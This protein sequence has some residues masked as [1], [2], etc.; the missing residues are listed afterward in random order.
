MRINKVY[1][2]GAGPSSSLITARGLL[3]LR[4]ADVV[5]YDY[6]VDYALLNEAKDGAQLISCNSLGKKCHLDGF[7]HSQDKINALMVKKAK[8]GKRVIRL[9][10]GDPS[11]FSRISQELAALAENK[12]GFEVVPGVTSA[13]SAACFLGIPLTD[14]RF[15]SSVVFVTGHEDPDKDKSSIDWKSIA[16]CGTIVLYMAV[17]NISKISCELIKCGR[18]KDTPVMAISYAGCLNQKTIKAKLNDISLAVRKERIQP[19]AIFI[20][21]K[22]VDFEK[23]FNWLKKGQRILFTGLS[24]E[25][26]FTKEAYF[27]LPLI[28]IIPISD[29]TEF[30]NYLK[31]IAGYDWLIFTSRYGA[32]YFF[33]RLN[34]VGLDSRELKNINIAAIGNSTKK[35]LQ[36]FGII[37]DLVPENESSQ[38]ILEEFAKI[39]IRDRKIFLPR[40]NLSD[41]GLT[42]KLKSFGAK[43]TAG[44]CYKNVMPR[45]LPDL[46]LNTFSE[47]MFTSPSGVRNFVQRYGGKIPKKTKVSCIGGVTLK[48]AKRLSLVR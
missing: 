3:I 6:L 40:S 8:E 18:P 34:A 35:R 28:S 41:K 45:H 17:E 4:Q 32:E 12:I 44:V 19:P 30:D 16:G 26:F 23:N 25:R 24:N 27:H 10:N 20:I 33:R 22:V 38:G 48:E 31:Q 1:L 7:L 15:S 43:V 2:V 11:I 39:D 14:R 36:D 5:I 46:D 42:E 21:G 9:K 29:Y 13:S 37:A 47:I